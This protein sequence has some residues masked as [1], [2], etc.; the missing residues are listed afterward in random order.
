M[1]WLRYILLMLPIRLRK[2]KFFYVL[3]SALTQYTRRRYDEQEAYIRQ[4][5]SDMQYTSESLSLITLLKLRFGN[6]VEIRD[7]EGVE[8]ISMIRPDNE[9]E[10]TFIPMMVR[11]DKETILQRDF[12]VYVPQGVDKEQVRSFVE[13]YVFCGIYFDV[14]Y[15]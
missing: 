11:P 5:L 8:N 10:N 1:N 15:K 7:D 4:L 9:V 12:I 3:I 2:S 6:D 13:R 14:E